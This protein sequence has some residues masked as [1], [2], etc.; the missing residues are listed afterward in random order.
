VG[1]RTGDHALL[2]QRRLVG[3]AL[4]QVGWWRLLAWCLVG[5]LGLAW[6]AIGSARAQ[7]GP[8]VAPPPQPPRPAAGA[9]GRNVSRVGRWVKLPEVCD[10]S[11]A[12]VFAQPI[13]DLQAEAQRHSARAT[14]FVEVGPGRGTFAGIRQVARL[15]SQ[16]LPDLQTVAWVPAPLTGP[17][18]A[19][20]L[21]CRELAL[22]AEGEL[23][24]LS[25]GQPLD[26]DEQ[27]FLVNLANRGNNPL[28][29]ESLMLGLLD[30]RRELLWVQYQGRDQQR[31]TRVLLRSELK[32]LQQRGVVIERVQTLKEPDSPG[33]LTAQKCRG[34]GIV[35][36]HFA[37]TRGEV[38]QAVGLQ[39]NQ[40][41]VEPAK[42][43]PGRVLH[44]RLQG[45]LDRQLVDF[46]QRQLRQVTSRKVNRLLV[47]IDLEGGDPDQA[48]A[49]ASNFADLQR[50]GVQTVA[51]IPT[52]ALGAAAILPLGCDA[53]WMGPRAEWGSVVTGGPPDRGPNEPANLRR[54]A[55]ALSELAQRCQ[56]SGAL[57]SAM[58]S[59]TEVV[60]LA[61]DADGR[62]GAFSPAELAALGPGW[63]VQGPVPECG[64]GQPLLL[65]AQRATELGLAEQT[66]ADQQA[67]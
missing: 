63:Q 42:N 27:A 51:W 53:V 59:N 24:D 26:P 47:E 52:S 32:E 45:R 4:F 3:E 41:L 18:A 7:P 43:E 22:S 28:L 35:A 66:V 67:V 29:N 60:Q 11:T 12:A 62:V 56:R 40:L 25:S 14:L 17:R 6:G 31:A 19:V 54:R 49:L 55:M 50:D 44:L 30:R 46:A 57:A 38:Q 36:R 21:A 33:L 65:S 39:P 8:P 48:L 5:S 13:L 37:D 10:E 20:A 61:R 16:E 64:T 1:L 34:F 58:V 2:T 9:E 23:G 15:L